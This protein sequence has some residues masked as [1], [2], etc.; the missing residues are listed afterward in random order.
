MGESGFQCY[1][2]RFE[3][4]QRLEFRLAYGESKW[5][6]KGNILNSGEKKEFQQ[7]WKSAYCVVLGRQVEC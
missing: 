3:I 5:S 7:E 6:F 4:S 1:L 2:A